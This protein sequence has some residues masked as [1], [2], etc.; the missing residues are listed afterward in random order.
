MTRYQQAQL[1]FT[2]M[3]LFGGVT[4]PSQLMDPELRRI[5]DLL[6]DEALVDEVYAAMKR[7]WPQS[8][9]RGRYGTPAEVALRMLVLKHL[10]D[11]TYESLEWEVKGNLVYRRF[12]RIEAGKVPDAKTLIRLAKVVEGRAIFDR[13]VGIAVERKVTKGHRM[14][15]DTTVID[16]PMHYPTDSGLCADV[17][18]VMR[19]G[20]ARLEEAGV[21]LPFPLRKVGKS[22]QRRLREIAQALR[23]RGGRAAEAIKKPYKRLL[24]VTGRLV[25]QGSRAVDVAGKG[26]GSLRGLRRR[27]ALRAVAELETMLPRARQILKQ[28]RARILRGITDSSG[29]LVSIFEPH[30]QIL[31]RGKIHKPTEFGV[32]VKIQE[33]DG[34]IITDVDFAP[35]KNDAPLLVPAVERHKV[36]F[37]RAPRM[38]ATDRGFWSGRGER[39]IKELGVTRSVT[40]KPGYKS[41]A[42]LALERERWFRRG[43][44]WRQGGEAR[45]S[46]LKHSFGMARSRNKGEAGMNRTVLWAGIAANLRTLARAA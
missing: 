42:R 37:G 46:Q 18:R 8:S 35:E 36:V 34:G 25:R 1:G 17:V 41:P 45:I 3:L 16:A 11:W 33:A 10:R 28:T 4:D 27:K 44:A 9:R 13:I 31:R 15:V 32:L 21:R 26:V 40:P 5:D 2:Q 38:V 29:K 7:R 23:L 43:R 12:C 20:M 39:R 22:V 14:R 24:R 19:R 30:A 6:G